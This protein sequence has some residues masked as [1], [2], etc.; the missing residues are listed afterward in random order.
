MGNYS[1]YFG[2]ATNVD[3]VVYLMLANDLIH[4]LFPEAVTVGEDVSGMPTF[5]IPVKDGGVGFDYRLHMAIADKWIEL[6]LKKKDE[7]WLMGDIVHTLSN[8]RWLEKCVA[9]AE[10]HDQAL[11]GDKTTI[12]FWLMDK[13]SLAVFVCVFVFHCVFVKLLLRKHPSLGVLYD[14]SLKIFKFCWSLLCK[15]LN[16]TLIII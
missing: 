16:L 7:E 6:L 4:G 5:C 14:V 8:R 2:F 11:G 3:A 1:E 13:V 9:D 12:A 10:S 15:G